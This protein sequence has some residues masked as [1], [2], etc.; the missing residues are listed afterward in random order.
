MELGIELDTPTS[1]QP[2]HLLKVIPVGVPT[3]L[4]VVSVVAAKIHD[5]GSIVLQNRGDP[6][7]MKLGRYVPYPVSSVILQPGKAPAWQILVLLRS[8]VIGVHRTRGILI[9]YRIDGRMEQQF[10]K[11]ALELE[12]V[13]CHR[14]P[15]R[16]A[17][18]LPE[19]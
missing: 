11:Q 17:C 19:D 10:L 15:H 9:S 4:A 3:G 1:T 16:I 8:S 2:V 12:I 14:S 18:S 5:L 13:D 7:K 6:H